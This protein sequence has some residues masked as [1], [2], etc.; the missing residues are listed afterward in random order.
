MPISE[1]IWL[2]LAVCSIV[3]LVVFSLLFFLGF[4]PACAWL[5]PASTF[6]RISIDI[7]FI[8]WFSLWLVVVFA[9]LKS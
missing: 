3:L 8:S 7:G 9:V 4:L 1:D 2:A 6:C 5:A